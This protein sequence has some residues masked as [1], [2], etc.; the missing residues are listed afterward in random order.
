MI[1]A[2]RAPKA[3]GGGVA[4][5]ADLSGQGVGGRGVLLIMSCT[6]VVVRSYTLASLQRPGWGRTYV[7]H[8][9]SR[10]TLDPRIPTMP[11]GG[12]VGGVYS[13]SC[14]VVVVW[15]ETLASLQ[16]RDGARRVFSDQA[17]TACTKREPS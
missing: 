1:L 17:D 5:T 2:S 13:F 14:M 15:Q 8:V 9:C 3:S 16:C 6:A 12:R 4:A 7:M 10:T 11:T